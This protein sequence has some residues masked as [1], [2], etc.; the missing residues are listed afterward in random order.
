M[1][2]PG[3]PDTES[4]LLR[5][6]QRSALAQAAAVVLFALLLRGLHARFILDT[7][8][9]QAPTADE[10]EHWDLARQL[11]SGNWLGEG[12][13]PYFRPQLFAYV[14]AGLQLVTGGSI[15]LVHLLLLV[16]DAATVGVMYLVAR[17]VWPRRSALLGAA[18]LAGYAP[19]IYFSATFNKEPFAIHLHAWMLLALVGWA[20]RPSLRLAGTVGLLAGLGLLCRPPLFLSWFALLVGMFVL[21]LR[22]GRTGLRV[23]LH[24]ALALGVSLLVLVPGAVRNLTVGN[25][26]VLYSN[27]G[28]LNLYFAN[29]GEGAGP[30]MH[31]PG[32]GWDLLIERSHS[33][34]GV[35]QRDYPAINR[36]WRR[37]FLD[38]ATG[39]PVP[40]LR[41]LGEKSLQVINRREVALT[42]P[43]TEVRR[44]SPVLALAPG[45]GVLLPLAMAGAVATMLASGRPRRRAAAGL[46]L[47]YG[48]TSLAAAALVFPVTRDRLAA[49]AVLVLFAGCGV[50]ALLRLL[51]LARPR[52]RWTVRTLAVTVAALLIGLFGVHLPLP[53]RGEA[54][55]E[56]WM[57]EVNRGDALL[58]L[59]QV[60][61]KPAQ[62]QE[63]IQAYEQAL[64]IR[65]GALQPLKQLPAAHARA[66]NAAEAARVQAEL[67]RRLREEYP[68]RRIV[69]GR[70]LEILTRLALR[71]RDAQL[72]LDAIREWKSLF[73]SDPVADALEAEVRK[74]SHEPA[75]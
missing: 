64:R 14:L 25:A 18:L 1:N 36:F 7:P 11:A 50:T 27:H 29:N 21:L 10:F 66:G 3:D 37:K 74:L 69:R 72:A 59:W 62:L 40:F 34:G 42:N 70:E 71:A 45:T 47:L 24:P 6:L 4:R 13:G 5:R 60:E 44:R 52:K 55:F 23:L 19:L 9:F 8:F 28:W 15:A 2:P 46:L 57:T 39:Q 22:N 67:V 58:Q 32:I 31:S 51:P 17:R 30:M 35:D 41:G 54:A 73:G 56:A 48:V 20:R 65:P 61:R 26:P 43:M 68:D 16:M 33:E 63:A 75:Q 49:M 53:D 12:L 38:Y